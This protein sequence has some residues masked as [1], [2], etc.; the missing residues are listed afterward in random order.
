MKGGGEG[1]RVKG[2]KVG[3]LFRQNL[4]YSIKGKI[5]LAQKSGVSLP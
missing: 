4:A 1:E 2:E 5:P 3:L